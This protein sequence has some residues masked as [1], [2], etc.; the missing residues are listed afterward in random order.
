MLTSVNIMALLLIGIAVFILLASLTLMRQKSQFKLSGIALI[1]D[2]LKKRA[3]IITGKPV[4]VFNKSDR[5]VWLKET[6][7]CLEETQ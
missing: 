7:K 5:L 3:D 2:L 6:K 1:K 4:Y